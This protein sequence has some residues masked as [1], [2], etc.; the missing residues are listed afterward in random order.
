MPEHDQT[1]PLS[2]PAWA[3]ATCPP[4]RRGAWT[5]SDSKFATCTGCSSR[6]REHISEVGER[7]LKLDARPG[8][9]ADARGRRPPGFASRPPA[10]LGVIAVR[11]PRSSADSRVWLARDGRVHREEERPPR[12]VHSVLSTLCWSVAEARDI[13]G[14]DDRDDVHALLRYLDRLVDQHITRDAELAVEVDAELRS[15]VGMLRPMTGDRRVQIGQC[16]QMVEGESGLQRCPAKIPSPM[17]N[18]HTV[19]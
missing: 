7:Y 1:D 2:R 5:Q 15:L 17:V 11:D 13:P 4:P 8:A 6:M 9:Y 12:S 16:P 18:I 14:P 10:N 3:C 19:S